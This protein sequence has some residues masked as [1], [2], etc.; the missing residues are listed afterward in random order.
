LPGSFNDI[1]TMI[2]K[3]ERLEP[4]CTSTMV[5]VRVRVRVSYP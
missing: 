2:A 1:F 4:Y 3:S 5:R